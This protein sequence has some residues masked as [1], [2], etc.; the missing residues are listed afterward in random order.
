MYEFQMTEA[1]QENRYLQIAA[2]IVYFNTNWL[3]IQYI[4]SSD[5]ELTS[6]FNSPNAG[7]LIENICISLI[8]LYISYECINYNFS[9]VRNKN[10]DYLVIAISLILGLAFLL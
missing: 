5:P 1:N 4:F 10:I 7:E 9:E 3:S 8:T 6:V 2:R